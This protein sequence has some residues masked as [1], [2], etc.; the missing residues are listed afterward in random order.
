MSASGAAF[1]WFLDSGGGYAAAVTLGSL[2]ILHW[3]QATSLFEA[4]GK[5][6]LASLFV[7]ALFII[8]LALP[9]GRFD[10]CPTS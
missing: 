9:I 6:A 3:D 7:I 2:L 4:Y 5:P 10:K 1:Q 8:V